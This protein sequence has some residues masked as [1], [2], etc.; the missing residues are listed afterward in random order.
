MWS[1]ARAWVFSRDKHGICYICDLLSEPEG[2]AAEEAEE[3]PRPGGDQH[4]ER[5]G[6]AERG[7]RPEAQARVLPVLA[8]HMIRI[9]DSVLSRTVL[10]GKFYGWCS[11]VSEQKLSFSKHLL[12]AASSMALVTELIGRTRPPRLAEKATATWNS[13]ATR[14]GDGR[15]SL[16]SE[17][18]DEDEPE[19]ESWEALEGLWP[20]LPAWEASR[21]SVV[22]DDAL[23]A[24]S[25]ICVFKF[26][27]WI[28]RINKSFLVAIRGLPIHEL[29]ILPQ[30]YLRQLWL[31]IQLVV[32]FRAVFCTERQKQ[33]ILCT[34]LIRYSFRN[35]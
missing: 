15:R 16:P 21:T 34:C 18:S 9:H 17:L 3:Q 6:A 7:P 35:K 13:C 20:D 1:H 8:A 24:G 32:S 26:L 2:I 10:L 30:L 31:Q 33:K 25:Y 14:A 19:E 12:R 22:A 28:H 27:L 11:V 29:T 23:C 4:D 5:D